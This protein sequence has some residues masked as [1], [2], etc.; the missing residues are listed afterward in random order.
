MK[1]RLFDDADRASRAVARVIAHQLRLKPASVLGLPTGRTSVPVYKELVRL[2]P[3][4]S[5]AHTFNLDEFVG[6]AA[7]NRRS[8]H[9]FMD[10]HLFCRVNI[11]AG[12]VHFLDGAAQDLDAECAR[13][14]RAIALA[15]GIDLLLLGIGAN[16]H[17]GFNEPGTALFARTHRA[18]LTAATRR[19]NAGL[20]AGRP[21]MVPREALSMGIGTILAARAIVL[22]ATGRSKA[23]AINAMLSGRITPSLPASFL[24]L[25]HD[26]QLVLDRAAAA[27]RLSSSR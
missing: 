1:V 19:A 25:H 27:R 23:R 2:R 4:F 18:R 15:G 17:I 21:A 11:P 24:Q 6:V 8:F 5:R 9:A 20:F 3:D 12:H 14:E 10:R 13:F 7:E 26:V 16:G 22:V